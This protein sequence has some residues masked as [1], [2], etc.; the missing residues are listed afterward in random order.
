MKRERERETDER[1]RTIKWTPWKIDGREAFGYINDNRSIFTMFTIQPPPSLSSTD[2]M[3]NLRF[4]LAN[5]PTKITT[6]RRRGFQPFFG[7]FHHRAFSLGFPA[8]S[9]QNCALFPF[10]L[11]VILTVVIRSAIRD[12]GDLTLVYALFFAATL[13][14]HISVAMRRFRSEGM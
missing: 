9:D 5:E 8:T 7:L 6:I 13:N 12:V 11:T 1:E 2:I 3:H 4:G 14:I 10:L